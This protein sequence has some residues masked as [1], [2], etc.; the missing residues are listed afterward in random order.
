LSN[1]RAAEIAE[2]FQRICSGR[3]YQSQVSAE[4]HGLRL[5]VSN[6]SERTIVNVYNTGK[7]QVQGK[8]NALKAEMDKLR[9]EYE[10]DPQTFAGLG[11]REA[12]ASAFKYDIMLPALREKVKKSLDQLGGKLE[13]TDNPQASVEYRAKIG[14]NDLGLTVT[15]FSNGS[16][17]LQG[18]DDALFDEA[19][20]NVEKTCNPSDKEVIT[21]FIS[22]D[23]SSLGTF[24]AKYTPRLIEMATDAVKAGLGDVYAYLEP[25]DQKWFVAS[26]CLRLA[27]VPLPEYSPV[28]M[29]ASKAFEGFAK[30]TLVGIGLFDADHFKIKEANFSLLSDKDHPRRKAVCAKEKYA[31]TMLQKIKVCLDT[32]RNFMMHSDDSKVTKIESPEAAYDKLDNIYGDTREIFGYFK[33]V[34]GLK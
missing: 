10:K 18:K 19:C 26:Q 31:D 17:V 21:R 3:N 8:Q 12:K 9:S 6:L 34:F 4:Q 29:P 13:I 30:K 24:V 15:Q 2:V 25:H 5:D 27:D 7:V 14:R 11:I 1:T 23:E 32:N 28:V 20:D 33:G 16:L 22:R